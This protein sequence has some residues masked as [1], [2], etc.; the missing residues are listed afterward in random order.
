MEQKCDV[1]VIGGG[2]TGIR[3][4]V[5]AKLCG[6]QRVILVNKGK[7]SQ[8]G[9][10]FSDITFGWDMQ[11][12]TGQNDPSDSK[13]Q[14]FE[15][16]MR[17]AQGT[18]SEELAK[19]LVDEAPARVQDLVT[20]FDLE[21]Y[22]GKNSVPR[23]VYGCFSSKSRSYQFINPKKIQEKMKKSIAQYG[24]ELLEE[25]M[26]VSLLTDT[27]RCYGAAAINRSGESVIFRAGAVILA[28]GGA[29]GIYKHNFATPGMCGDGYSLALRSGCTVA[30]MEF[31]QF[32]LGLLEP[33]Y[34]A[35]FLDR[36]LYL[37]PEIRFEQKHVFPCSLDKMLEKHAKHFP[38]SCIDESSSFDVAI[39]KETLANKRGVEV[40]LSS[41]PREKLEEI[42]VW[43]LYYNWFEPEN[44]PYDTPLRITTFAH[45]CNGGV[46]IDSQARTQLEGLYAAG[47]MVSGPHGANRLGGNMHAACQVFAARAGRN[48]AVYAREHID[49]IRP[50]QWHSAER[51]GDPLNFGEVKDKVGEEMW[52]NVNVCRNEQNMQSTKAVLN[53]LREALSC[54][55]VE[56]AELWDYYEAESAV[57]T[58]LAILEAAIERRESRGSHYREDHPD[59]EDTPYVVKSRCTDKGFITWRSAGFDGK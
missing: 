49:G 43:D 12:A 41:I 13:Q 26:V 6:A 18:C 23:Q 56:K 39:F 20:L 48:A 7:F 32:G 8:T 27:G 3:A 57:L 52:R 54:C 59:T 15:D 35:L 9:V 34:R 31:M 36:L 10:V 2:E 25:L 50:L 29:T 40:R 17:A 51:C 44:N 11:A 37:K 38:F 45:A 5:E 1:L 46:M 30:N 28:A 58:G 4:A 14:H 19:I 16:I 53:G 21:L 24:V 33:K 47:E 55:A 42:P 22:K